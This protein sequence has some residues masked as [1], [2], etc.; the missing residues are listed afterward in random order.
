LNDTAKSSLWQGRARVLAVLASGAL[1][2]S[3]LATAP[4]IAGVAGASEANQPHPAAASFA[5]PVVC[6]TPSP[7]QFSLTVTVGSGNET[8]KSLFVQVPTDYTSVTPVSAPPGTIT[9]TLIP[10]GGYSWLGVTG[11]VLTSSQS[12]TVNFTA[13]PAPQTSGAIDTWIVE[14]ET[15]AD[16]TPDYYSSGEPNGDDIIPTSPVT[17][18]AYTG[19]HLVF[20]A[21]GQPASTALNG[22]AAPISA[23]YG[24]A[25][26]SPVTVQVQDVNNTPVPIVTGVSLALNPTANAA[27]ANYT[28]T[29]SAANGSASFASPGLTNGLSGLNLTLTASATTT[30]I[31]IAASAPSSPFN[32]YTSGTL[33]S[34]SCT[35]PPI[36]QAPGYSVS[37][38]GNGTGFLAAFLPSFTLSCSALQF[39]LYPGIPGTTTL[40]FTYL[41]NTTSTKTI[42]LFIAP[43]LLKTLSAKLLALH[44]MVCFTAP[45]EF[46]TVFGLQAAYD[47]TT[48]GLVDVPG[49]SWY[50]G[51][52]PDCSAKGSP[53]PCV[54]SR[55]IITTATP[56]YPLLG[57]YVTVLAPAGPEDPFGR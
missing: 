45:Y 26:T 12:V 44:Y 41:N 11:L 6:A 49:Q 35:T 56:Q 24:G 5:S 23:V 22:G 48:T 1:L 2:G 17:T 55:T 50:T 52:L 4:I 14:G 7:Q 3:A 20:T 36:P 54:Q 34:G 31:G 21:A 10:Y 51:L 57:V 47:A 32:I 28:S 38:M 15:D 25:Y 33:C 40:G 18:T 39:G 37:S 42:T 8:L 46:R 9:S 43:L 16:M 30:G 13:I 29:T 53:Q 27:L 19:C